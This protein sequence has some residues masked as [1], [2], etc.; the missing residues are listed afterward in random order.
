MDAKYTPNT[1]KYDH[2][3]RDIAGK[4]LGRVVLRDDNS[5]SIGMV[6][7]QVSLLK[8][9][10]QF[11]DVILGSYI[12]IDGYRYKIPESFPDFRLNRREHEWVASTFILKRF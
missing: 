12:Y 8:I 4:P 9:P 2:V 10:T 5:Y 6:E 7:I 11:H 3:I 1:F